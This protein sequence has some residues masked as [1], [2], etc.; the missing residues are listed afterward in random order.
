[1][2]SLVCRGYI[3]LVQDEKKLGY[4]FS[5][6]SD[7]VGLHLGNG[8]IDRKHDNPRVYMLQVAFR[9]SGI[10]GFRRS[11]ARC[12]DKDDPSLKK[13]GRIGYFHRGNLL[14]VAR[15]AGFRDVVC[16]GIQLDFLSLSSG[17]N[18][19]CIWSRPVLDFRDDG[20]HGEDPCG[21]DLGPQKR[22]DKGT[23][24]SLHLAE[25]RKMK[26]VGYEFLFEG[27]QFFAQASIVGAGILDHEKSV[28]RRFHR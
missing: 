23:L 26:L 28:Q 27:E 3:G 25:N 15:I 18:D 10:V 24:A 19:G 21:Q 12:I 9:G 8:R 17:I 11:N 13:G 22:I 14:L 4:V 16:Q 20:G 1:M 6:I 5:D 7:E 2:Q